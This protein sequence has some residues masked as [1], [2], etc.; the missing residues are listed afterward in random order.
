MTKHTVNI[1]KHGVIDPDF[2]CPECSNYRPFSD[3]EL[4]DLSECVAEAMMRTDDADRHKR[5]T[6]LYKKL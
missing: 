5:L 4:A 6:A 2:E 3:G 1:C